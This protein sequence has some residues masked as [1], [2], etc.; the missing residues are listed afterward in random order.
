MLQ[1]RDRT[2]WRHFAGFALLSVILA[3]CGSWDS[4]PRKEEVDYFIANPVDKKENLLAKDVPD[5]RALQGAAHSQAIL[6]KMADYDQPLTGPIPHGEGV[7]SEFTLRNNT[8]A[9]AGGNKL[10]TEG[11]DKMPT[12]PQTGGDSGAS[13]GSVDPASEDL[14]QMLEGKS[15]VSGNSNSGV[16]SD[17]GLKDQDPNQPRQVEINF[18]GTSLRSVIEFVFG[19]YIKQPYVITSEFA[20]K[21]VNWIA[22]GEFS[23][24]EIRRMFESFLDLQDVVVAKLDGIYTIG[25]RGAISRRAG[26]GE[27]GNASG[28]WRLKSLDAGEVLQIIRPFIS[29]PEGA[30]ILDRQN[31]LVISGSGSEIRYVDAFLKTLDV[32]SFSEKHVIVYAPKHI[33]AEAMVTLLQALPQQLGM[34]SAEGKKQI[35]AALVTGAKRVVIVADGKETR[36][37]VH[38]YVDQLDQPGKGQKQVFYYA[39]RNQLVDDVKGTLS[40]LL[41][42]LL[43]DATEITAV[44]NTP[45]NSLMIT[46]TPDQFFEIKKVI[47]RLD[48]RI[49]SVLI[50][51]TIVEVQ[52]NDNLAYGVEWFLGGRLGEVKGD[53]T[54]S[55]GN[56]AAIATPAARI[57]VVALANNTFATLD[58]LASETNL[59]VLSRPRV[60][61]KNRATATIKSTDQVRIVKSV[62][63][64]SVQQ[65]GDNIPKREFEDKE[66]GVSL[67]VTP[68]IAEDGTVNLAVKIQDSRQGADDDASG[69]RPR[70]NVR[71]VNTELVSQ[72]GKT[73]LIGGLIRDN[74]IRT[75]NKVPFF[76]DIPFLG[77]AFANTNDVEQRT[78]LVIFLTPY[79]VMDEVSARLVSEAI[80][81]LARINPDILSQSTTPDPYLGEAK[82]SPADV[83]PSN[84][85]MTPAMPDKT[86]GNVQEDLPAD[87]L[88][89]AAESNASGGFTPPPPPNRPFASEPDLRSEKPAASQDGYIYSAKPSSTPPTLAP[90]SDAAPSPSPDQSS[91]PGLLQ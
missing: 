83:I 10:I 84:K 74:N 88:E 40:T 85:P 44:G 68:R 76:G 24:L 9:G 75:K 28:I 36:D 34:N 30:T 15:G 19:E 26:G 21:E 57:G 29:N 39:L 27:I 50:D 35:E 82:Q 58:L 72:N 33:S 8:R 23:N 60:L 31:T 4:L 2:Y 12:P 56:A 66:V 17:S 67:Q 78:E 53:I 5:A 90:D 54:T 45:N 46:A 64:T 13:A 14:R 48:Y 69:E 62:L 7:V 70:F 25:N 79:L 20:D 55:L 91:T 3:A 43:P 73:I 51:A 59:T 80:S 1:F 47:D 71:E 81:G 49:P 65:G 41:P 16:L 89:D 11:P 18:N 63:T 87:L 38:Q 37:L 86:S 22:Q 32:P 77:Q 6:D 61:V 42:G 52:L